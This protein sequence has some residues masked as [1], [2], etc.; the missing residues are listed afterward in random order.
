MKKELCGQL[1]ERQN[2]RSD[3]R[4]QRVNEQIGILPAIEAEC[5]LVQVKGEMLRAD[6]VP[7]SNDA[8][9]QEREGGLD[10]VGRDAFSPPATVRTQE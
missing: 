9:L 10:G 3:H 8:A 6:L 5:H 2:R 7:R 1:L 4:A